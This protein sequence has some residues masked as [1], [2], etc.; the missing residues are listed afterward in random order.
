M[1][2]L[3]KAAPQAA[4]VLRPLCRMLAIETAVL[5]PGVVAVETV[6]VPTQ[7]K[8]APREKPDTGRVPIPRGVM[9]WVRRDGLAKG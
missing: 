9:A 4:R 3:L 7:R 8:R 1:V 2:E 5:R 6:V